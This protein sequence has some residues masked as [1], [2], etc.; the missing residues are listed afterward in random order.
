MWEDC[1]DLAGTVFSV[2][3]SPDTLHWPFV[4]IDPDTGL[5]DYTINVLDY[6]ADF[7]L[8]QERTFDLVAPVMDGIS[9]S[10]IVIADAL[11]FSGD[12]RFLF[13]DAFNELQLSDVPARG[14]SI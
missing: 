9:T 7:N 12:N 8:Q 1:L 10:T 11:D 5:A 3:M 4:F 14:V 6:D 13:Y 2:A